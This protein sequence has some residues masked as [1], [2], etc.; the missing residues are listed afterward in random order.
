M[1]SKASSIQ[2]L[3]Q[4]ST[5]KVGSVRQLESRSCI[6]YLPLFPLSN[7]SSP[8]LKFS[9]T[10]GIRSLHIHLKTAVLYS[11]LRQ[12]RDYP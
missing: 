11:T 7:H 8:F 10:R 3:V 6:P 9:H 5:T 12:T 2:T 1:P 4:G